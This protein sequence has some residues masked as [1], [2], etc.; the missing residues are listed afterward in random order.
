MPRPDAAAMDALAAKG[1][2]VVVTGHLHVAYTGHTAARY[3]AAGRAAIVVEAR[4]AQ[5]SSRRVMVLGMVSSVLYPFQRRS[6]SACRDDD[7]ALE[8]SAGGADKTC[9]R[10]MA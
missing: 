4:S 2:D 5:Q 3:K 7:V 1:V 6:D 8:D 9:P 10:D